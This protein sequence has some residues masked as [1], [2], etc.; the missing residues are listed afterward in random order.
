MT[1][2]EF[3]GGITPQII[4]VIGIFVAAG[5]S[6]YASPQDVGKRMNNPRRVAPIGDLRSKPGGDPDAP[7]RQSQQHHATVGTDAATI[8]CGGDLLAVYRWQRERQQAIVDHGGCGSVRLG[9][10]LASTPKSLRQFSRLRYIRQRIPAMLVNRP[11]YL[12]GD[13][14]DHAPP[15]FMFASHDS[16]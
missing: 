5:N 10:R 3:E 8:E 9:E 6:Q 7:L 13:F 11:G 2:G 16:L 12:T 4:Q 1:A 15:Q 14:I